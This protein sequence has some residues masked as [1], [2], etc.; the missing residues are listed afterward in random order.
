MGQQ[1]GGVGVQPRGIGG[2]IQAVGVVGREAQGRPQLAGAFGDRGQSGVDCKVASSGIFW[3]GFEGPREG[4]N[5]PRT[6]IQHVG[7]EPSFGALEVEG[8]NL[9]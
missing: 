9:E 7:C 4:T 3:G 1:R 6:S 8:G 2:L 5:V